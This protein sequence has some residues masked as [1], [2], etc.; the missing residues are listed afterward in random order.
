MKR[1]KSFKGIY[2]LLLLTG[3]LLNYACKKEVTQNA[4]E[5]IV[6][7]TTIYNDQAFKYDLGSFGIEEGAI[8]TKQATH[9]SESTIERDG[10]KIIYKYKPLNGFS[11]KDEVVIKSERGSYGVN[12][13]NKVKYT[14]IMIKVLKR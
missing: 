12:P 7:D 14:G 4:D 3:F 11:G 2:F 5:N 1:K 8:I 6:M 9:F 13:G 10:M